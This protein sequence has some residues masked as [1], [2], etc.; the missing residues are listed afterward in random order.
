MVWERASHLPT[1]VI[2]YSFQIKQISN[3]VVGHRSTYHLFVFRWRIPHL[4]MVFYHL[5]R[6]TTD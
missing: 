1:E 4:V 6:V 2:V 5:A 3:F